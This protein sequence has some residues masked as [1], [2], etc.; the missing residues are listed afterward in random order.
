MHEGKI[1]FSSL[2]VAGSIR[3]GFFKTKEGFPTSGNDKPMAEV[4][5]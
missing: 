3:K 4:A 1:K 2:N 5:M